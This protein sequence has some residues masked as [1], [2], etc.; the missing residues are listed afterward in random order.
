M[1][2]TP[3]KVGY[4]RPADFRTGEIKC[5]V[6][7][8]TFPRRSGSGRTGEPLTYRA[9]CRSTVSTTPAT[10][11]AGGAM[12]ACDCPGGC[13]RHQER[14]EGRSPEKVYHPRGGDFRY[15]PYATSHKARRRK[16]FVVGPMPLKLKVV[17]P[18]NILPDAPCPRFQGD[19]RESSIRF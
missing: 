16:K 15:R 19:R 9:S 3:R 4:T 2:Y 14:R 6:S 8:Y 5:A 12:A 17:N 7:H 1:G 18:K 10:S 11:D 13:G